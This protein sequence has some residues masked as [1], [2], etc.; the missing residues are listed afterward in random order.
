MLRATGGDR[1]SGA[2]GLDLSVD[3]EDRRVVDRRLVR[4]DVE[5]GRRQ[6]RRARRRALAAAGQYRQER[7]QQE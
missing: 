3:D 6:N 4:R 1:R 7:S 5:P 2:R